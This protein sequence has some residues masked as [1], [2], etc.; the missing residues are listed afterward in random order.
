[1]TQAFFLEPIRKQSL[2]HATGFDVL[3]FRIGS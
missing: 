3:R 1:M 2:A